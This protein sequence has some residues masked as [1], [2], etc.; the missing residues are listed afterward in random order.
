MPGLEQ[1]LLGGMLLVDG[2]YFYNRY[3]DLIVTLGGSLPYAEPLQVGQPGEFAGAGGGVFG[4]AAAVAL[5]A[6]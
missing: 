4:P 1:K 6:R 5:G 2:T 3:Y